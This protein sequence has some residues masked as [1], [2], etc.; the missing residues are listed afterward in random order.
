VN[1]PGGEAPL[2]EFL[3]NHLQNAGLEALV[4]PTPS[5]DPAVPRAAAWG[6]LAGSGRARPIVLLSHLDVVPAAAAEW[7]LPPFEGIIRDG[8]VHGRGSLDAKGVTVIQLL[9]ILELA[10]RSTPLE[11][12]VIFLATPDEENGGKL[13]AGYLAREHPELLRNAEFL[14]TEGGGIRPGNESTP[15]VW[16][17]T[18]SEKSPC[19]LEL[20]SR[21]TPGHSS[22]PQRDAAVPRLVAALDR[23]RRIETPIVVL[24]E[25]SRMFARL[26]PSASEENRIGY[27]ELDAALARDSGFR[28]RFLRNPGFNALVRNT[29]SITVLEGGGRTNVAP[30]EASAQLDIRLLPGESC[31]SFRTSIEDAI[32]AP[33]IAVS[34]ILSFP[35]RSSAAET[36]LFAAIERV[37]AER[38]PEALVIPRVIAAFTDAHWFRELGVVAYGFVPR[39]LGPEDGRGVHGVDERISVENLERGAEVLV[40]ILEEIGG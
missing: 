7:E 4:I 18:I 20:T 8:Y 16:G 28:R 10:R 2:A 38:D 40:R 22:T 24:P 6:R 5:A 27:S 9:T 31:E 23:I 14:L 34:T 1:P 29:I 12:D 3:V 32:S 26:A 11:R 25:V 33:E 21:G 30:A 36:K 19:W 35:S 39:R 17:V 13:G 37:A 15:P